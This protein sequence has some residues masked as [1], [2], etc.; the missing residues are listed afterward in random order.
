MTLN[1]VSTTKL[2]VPTGDT[3][4]IYGGSA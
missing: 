1:K 2:Y 3:L 4:V